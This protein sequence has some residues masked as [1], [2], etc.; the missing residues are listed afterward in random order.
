M[1]ILTQL[2]MQSAVATRKAYCEADQWAFDPRDTG[3]V[4]PICGW[5]PE[6][7]KPRVDP[8][9]VAKMRVVPWD[10]VSLGVLVVVLVVLGVLVAR[11]T[12][13]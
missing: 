12:G 1:S 13:S 7:G 11:A 8:F 10:F 3:G 6:E 9:L 4:C 2:R 5:K